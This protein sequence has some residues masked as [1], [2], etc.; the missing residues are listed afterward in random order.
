[1]FHT[2]IINEQCAQL[3]TLKN[4]ASLVAVTTHAQYLGKILCLMLCLNLFSFL[5]G[6]RE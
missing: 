1:M 4:G 2:G 3:D 6:L 5:P